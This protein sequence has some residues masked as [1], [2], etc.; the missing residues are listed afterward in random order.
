MRRF[1]P[2]S[3]A[4]EVDLSTNLQERPIYKLIISFLLYNHLECINSIQ[5]LYTYLKNIYTFIL[6]R[7]KIPDK[8][9]SEILYNKSIIY[10]NK[11]NRS[12]YP[13]L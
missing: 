12:L 7:S 5:I 3:S 9:I 6:R 4:N 10:S 13:N 2:K 8:L 1:L 11:I